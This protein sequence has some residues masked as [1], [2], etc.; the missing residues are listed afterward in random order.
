M[1]P[2]ACNAEISEPVQ[3]WVASGIDQH[4]LSDAELLELYRYSRSSFAL[5][6]IV[7]RHSPLVA[8]VIRRLVFN[9]QDAEDAFQATFLVLVLSV[10]K[11]RNPESLGSWL[12]GVAYRTAK[13]IRSQRKN[14]NIKMARQSTV[15]IDLDSTMSTVEDPLV[16]MVREL[17][18]EAMDT[19]LSK[20]PKNLREAL[21]EHYMAGNS[22]PEIARCLNL[23]VTAVE[24]RLKRG[25]KALRIRLAMRGISLTV[26][27][28]AC[29]RFQQDVVA[30]SAEPWA[31]RFLELIGNVGVA[32]P[33]LTQ[34][35]DT[36]TVSSQ[37]FKLVQGEYVVNTLSRSMIG[38]A[39]GILVLCAI[40]TLGFLSAL[41]NQQGGSATARSQG[42][43]ALI[44]ES[45]SDQEVETFVLGQAGGGAGGMG[46]GGMGG[47]G[48]GMGAAP[49][50]NM[51]KEVVIKWEKPA[52]PP[53]SWLDAKA[54][55]NDREVAIRSKLN[56]RMDIDND[57][58]PLVSVMAFIASQLEVAVVID[59]KA[60]EE[61]SITLDEPVTIH[62][63]DAMVRHI[64]N[65]VL[66]PLQLTYRIDLEAVFITSKKTSANEM[67][68]YDLSCIFPDNGLTT[69]LI[70]GIEAMVSPDNWMAAG[71]NSSMRTVGSMLV[72]SAPYET[73]LAVERFLQGVSK[74][75]AA[76]FKPRVFI[77]KPETK[78]A[79]GGKGFGGMM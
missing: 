72:I 2:T 40:G 74:Q 3:Q 65:Q 39:G 45:E 79:E 16:I 35:Q 15:G 71:G 4:A 75:P 21:I 70:S 43:L 38:S 26:V 24:G 18:L 33:T 30:A 29:I 37:L 67:G 27:A 14:D 22:V 66:E 60:L 69:E 1:D 9:S 42:T 25:R 28:A 49:A 57:A 12:Y 6:E 19:E 59:E 10:K 78:P 53:P 58:T 55:A 73:H 52:G 62:R 44:P 41:A 50:M 13:R 76:N 5:S 48:G 46:G 47:T 36:N 7:R 17:Q 61:E 34:L 68:F 63:K 8:S 77:E 23:S 56:E 64:L 11:I 31:N 32:H 51:P 20:L 54:S